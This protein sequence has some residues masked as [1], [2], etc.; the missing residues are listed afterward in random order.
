[1]FTVISYLW[2]LF[3]LTVAIVP[4]VVGFLSRPKKK[5]SLSSEPQ[6]DGLDESAPNE[7]VLDFGD[8][9]AQMD[10]AR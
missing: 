7:P 4:L 10:S 6:V 1:M 2:L 8:E 5:L 3:L 9:L